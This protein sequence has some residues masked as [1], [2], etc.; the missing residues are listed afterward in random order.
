MFEKHVYEKLFLFNIIQSFSG[1][2]I[3]NAM[4]NVHEP[5]ALNKGRYKEKKNIIF[6]MQYLKY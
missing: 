5:S 4:N 1:H 2:P 3:E 6:Q